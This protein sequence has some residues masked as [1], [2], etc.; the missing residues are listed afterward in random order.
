MPSLLLL[1]LFVAPSV[2]AETPKLDLTQYKNQVVYVDFWASWCEPCERSF[3]WLNQ[4]HKTLGSKGLKVISVNLD[5]EK[6]MAQTFLKKTPAQ[7]D[8]IYDPEGALAEQYQVKGMPTSVIF[9]R[10]GK[11]VAQHIGF[12][13]EIQKNA[14]IELK[15]LLEQKATP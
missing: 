1:L 6:A 7:F 8:V 11:Q 9:D 10:S 3:P 2:F 5:K 13:N 12:N 4:M 14:E 15:K